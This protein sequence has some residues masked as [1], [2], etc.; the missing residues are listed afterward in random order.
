MLIIGGTGFIGRHLVDACLDRGHE[1][2][3]FNRDRRPGRP[4]D[5]RHIVGDRRRPEP[6][7][8]ITASW[9]V[10]IDTCAYAAQDM[11]ISRLITTR[12]YVLLSTC[13]AYLPVGEEEI[14]DEDAP[15][16]IT[17]ELGRLRQAR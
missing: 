2:T 8:A 13:G 9:D 3:L 10:V 15:A 12:R 16:R 17:K 14:T 11:S 5:V 7:A 1:V 6:A 4:R